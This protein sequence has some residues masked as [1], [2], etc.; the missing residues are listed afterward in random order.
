M[1]GKDYK[2]DLDKGVIYSYVG[3]TKVRS[4]TD[5]AQ[6]FARFAEQLKKEK[7]K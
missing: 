4:N 3:G 6:V 5:Q 1:G 2:Y 7:K